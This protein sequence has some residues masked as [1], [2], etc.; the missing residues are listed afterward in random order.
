M[1]AV[2]SYNQQGGWHQISKEALLS[3]GI[4]TAMSIVRDKRVGEKVLGTKE[5]PSPMK[6]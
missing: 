6:V 2:H 1:E 3:K 5:L 4:G